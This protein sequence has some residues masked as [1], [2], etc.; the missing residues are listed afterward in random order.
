MGG[1]R[2]ENPGGGLVAEG[3]PG[4][5]PASVSASTPSAA[6]PCAPRPPLG[7]GPHSVLSP[8]PKL[9]IQAQAPPPADSDSGSDSDYEHYDFGAQPPV[10]LTTFYSECRARE[11]P[12][13]RGPP[14]G[15]SEDPC[16]ARVEPPGCPP[17]PLSEAPHG[18]VLSARGP[19]GLA[20]LQAWPPPPS[21]PRSPLATQGLKACPSPLPQ[22]AVS[23]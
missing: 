19:G 6:S 16:T 13:C 8:A 17:A 14:A 4:A 3:L 23:V 11:R 1:H 21:R 18:R 10:A 15:P 2:R 7:H 9:P 22:V 5:L 12:G 20:T